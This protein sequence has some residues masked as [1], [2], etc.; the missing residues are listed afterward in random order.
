MSIP[1]AFISPIAVCREPSIKAGC[2][3]NRPA[4]SSRCSGNFRIASDSDSVGE[5]ALDDLKTPA[6]LQPR[7][8]QERIQILA[9]HDLL[10]TSLPDRSDIQD[11]RREASV[12]YPNRPVQCVITLSPAT[13]FTANLISFLKG[14]SDISTSLASLSTM[15]GLSQVRFRMTRTFEFPD[16]SPA[17]LAI[18][19]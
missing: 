15:R 19:R 17:A 5:Y 10:R 1:F 13:V 12:L 4:S 14:V 2:S 18:S 8:A 3:Q 7:T 9:R 16:S 11:F 6:Q